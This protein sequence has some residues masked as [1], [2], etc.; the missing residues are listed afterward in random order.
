ML[1]QSLVVG[2]A[3]VKSSRW[4]VARNAVFGHQYRDWRLRVFKEE[5]VMAHTQPYDDVQFCASFVQ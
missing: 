4:V 3:G 5:A 2:M 1:S